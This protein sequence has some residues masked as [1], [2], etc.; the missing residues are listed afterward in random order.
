MT[1]DRPFDGS[2]GEIAHSWAGGDIHF[3]DDE[4]FQ[5]SSN[6]TVDSIDLLKV[7]GVF[8]VVF[9]VLGCF[10]CFRV[11]SVFWG[12]LGVNSINVF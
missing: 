8:W 3:D 12:V 7:G 11:F 2:G 5:R 9:G 6:V 1:C 10:W 4:N